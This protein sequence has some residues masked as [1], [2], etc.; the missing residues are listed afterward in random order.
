MFLVLQSGLFLQAVTSFYIIV[1]FF[2]PCLIL[3]IITNPLLAGFVEETPL[4]HACAR[5]FLD[6]VKLLLSHKADVNF[7]CSVS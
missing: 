1:I 6:I 3:Q 7:K 2:M 4:A 5:G